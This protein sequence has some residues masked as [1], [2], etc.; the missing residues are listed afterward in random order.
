MICLPQFI[1]GLTLC[2]G[3]RF[4]VTMFLPGAWHSYIIGWMDVT[5][6]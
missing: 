6:A 3:E 4:F 5:L 1:I 2:D